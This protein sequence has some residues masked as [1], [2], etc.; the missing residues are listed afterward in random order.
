MCCPGD[1]RAKSLELFQDRIRRGG[2]VERGLGLVVGDHEQLDFGDQLLDAGEAAP[3][4]RALGDD[5]KPALDLVQ[6]GGVG[7]GVVHVEAGPLGQPGPDLG[8]LV[9]AVVIDDQVDV[10][11]LGDG[12][13]DLPQKAQKFLVAMARLALGDHL[14]GGHVQRRK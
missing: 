2:P 3:S 10:K 5:P 4:D 12:L 11:L 9:G 1:L 13:L 14:A 6:P 8:M 7:G